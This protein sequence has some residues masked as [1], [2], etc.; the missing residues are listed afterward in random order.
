M[1]YSVWKV[2][3]AV[4]DER[5]AEI[6][7][8]EDAGAGE[9]IDEVDTLDLLPDPEE[10][11]DVF[12]ERMELSDEDDGTPPAWFLYDEQGGELLQVWPAHITPYDLEAAETSLT[13]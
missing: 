5:A 3:G 13:Q 7:L 6:E 11:P 12:A 4:A 8:D 1:K 10:T 9:V 2:N